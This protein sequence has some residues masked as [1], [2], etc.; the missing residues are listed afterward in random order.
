MTT[1]DTLY[2]LLPEIVLLAAATL[3]YLMGAF[4]PKQFSPA[5]T[6]GGAILVAAAVLLLQGLL[7]R[8][9]SPWHHPTTTLSGPI[10]VDVL[11]HMARWA[12]LLFGLLLVMT[13]SHS[14]VKPAAE[15]V[16]S[17][18]LI[19]AGLMLVATGF[20]LV[21][22]FLGLEL[23]SIPTYVVLYVGRRDAHGQEA[24]AKYF[25]LSVLSS[26]LL[27]YGFSFL[28]GL[29]GSTQ[30]DEIAR[31][32]RGPAGADVG[33]VA[34]LA[35][36]A[37]LLIFAGLG[38]RLTAA[39]F[40]FY[41]P[42]VYQ[43][44]SNLNA[45]LLSTLPKIA[46]LLALIRV[47]VFAMPGQ[48]ELAW[49]VALVMSVLTMTLGNVLALWQDNVRRL[50]AYSSI[51]HGGYLLIGVAVGLANLAINPGGGST[52]P[53]EPH[54]GDPISGVGTSLFYLF[55][56][57]L[58]TIGAFAS[59]KFLGSRERQIDGVDELAGLGKSRP[60]PALALAISMFSL[61]GV[62]PLAGFWGKLTLFSGA[63]SVDVGGGGAE[64]PLRPWFIGLAV[65]GAINA[66][67]G[68]AYY[69][70]I[71][72]VMYFRSPVTT[73]KAEG[74][75]GAWLAMVSCSLLVLA[76]GLFPGPFITAAQQAGRLARKTP[77]ESGIIQVPIDEDQGD[78]SPVRP[79]RDRR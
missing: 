34:K 41:A 54:S 12:I 71:V 55:V 49:R 40:H 24:A 27:L 17:L 19:L 8:L 67:I 45:G 77:G 42:D 18:V 72:A 26:A 43:G 25:F 28:Y 65:I 14:N 31:H 22:I 13:A 5:T 56:Y 78:A 75:P 15:Y 32:L 20:D 9:P 53:P 48:E 1:T 16:G 73:V 59:L 3:I 2:F 57:C 79:F 29:G 23:V 62:P 70:R 58:S 74:G 64:H 37:L 68:M 36:V 30:L 6:A 46:G 66:A 21:L 52:L 47:V 50:L 60:L 51:A 39:P 44:T 4:F 38:F 35:P 63:V 11:G 69:L 10:V 33:V 61:A 7:H 76:C